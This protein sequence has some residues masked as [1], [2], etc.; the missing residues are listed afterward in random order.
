MAAFETLPFL[1]RSI[2]TAQLRKSRRWWPGGESEQLNLLVTF[3]AL[4]ILLIIL[5]MDRLSDKRES[6]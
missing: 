5:K 4:T 6:S 2:L 1:T 3:K